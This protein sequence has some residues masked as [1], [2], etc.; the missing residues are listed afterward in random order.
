MSVHKKIQPIRS[1]RLA[2]QKKCLVLLYRYY[3]LDSA[4]APFEEV[5][6]VEDSQQ[7]QEFI[8]Y[9]IIYNFLILL[10]T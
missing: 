7:Y 3:Y 10:L 8:I 6:N 9:L 2:G 5:F 4:P 1:S